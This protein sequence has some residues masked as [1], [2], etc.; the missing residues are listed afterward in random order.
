MENLYSK[1]NASSSYYLTTFPP[2][3]I[4]LYR[5]SMAASSLFKYDIIRACTDDKIFG[6][7]F[8]G[9]PSWRPWLIFLKHLFGLAMSP[10][11]LHFVNSRTGRVPRKRHRY[12][13]AWLVV[14]RRGGKSF[15]LAVIA[16]FL[17]FFVD[18]KPYLAP[19]EF[20]TIVIVAQDRK[21]ARVIFR[22]I[23]GLIDNIQ[24]L[25]N[26]PRTK[27]TTWSIEFPKQRMA[28]EIF[29]TSFRATRGYTVVAALLDE[30]AFWRSE[31]T[32][33]P[34]EE[35][36]NA[37]R[38]GTATIP[39]AFILA[40]SSPY[41]KRG[42][43]YKNYNDYFGK[44]DPDVFV[45]SGDTRSMNS[46]ITEKYLAKQ[47]ERDPV[48][49]AAE[50]GAQFRSDIE[51]FVPEEV[52]NRVTQK[53]RFQIPYDPRITYYGFTDPSGGSRD[54][55][56]LAIGHKEGGDRVLDLCKEWKAPF[57][58]EEVVKEVSEALKDYCVL[59]VIGDHYAGN[60]PEERFRK[61]GIV[62]VPCDRSK[63]ELYRDA[64]PLLN[65][66]LVQLL[67]I[68]RIKTQICN[69]ER[70]QSRGGRFI[71]DHPPGGKDDVANVVLGL[72]ATMTSSEIN[73]DEACY[74]VGRELAGS[75]SP[76]PNLGEM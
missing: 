29:T 42:V 60:W 28:I 26:E 24:F 59:K 52:V 40:A 19:G 8:N 56:A 10:N 20:G 12:S 65:S 39:G 66:G 62:Y 67:D 3:Q 16:V 17:T 2:R 57:H 22:Y 71:I 21:Q 36:L 5:T 15:I 49:A 45:W 31:D 68:L 46:L 1:T 44:D 55:F 35:I 32:A 54:S 73:Y 37:I 43:L 23:R 34:D 7:W 6:P 76:M 38:P 69:L 4:R 63:S 33:N 48:K 25:R 30:V 47:Y 72:F 50:Y 27:D 13:E 70:R 75:S 64:L 14:G 61:N 18:W 58:P 11:D 41:A 9:K 53:G 74:I 51:D